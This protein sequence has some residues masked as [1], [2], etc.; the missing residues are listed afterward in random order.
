MAE[1]DQSEKPLFD[2]P[3]LLKNYY[4]F[5]L[6]RQLGL[7]AHSLFLALLH[8][9]NS[10]HFRRFFQISSK[11]LADLAVLT[12]RGARVARDKLLQLRIHGIPLVL[13]LEGNRGRSPIYAIIYEL[14]DGGDKDFQKIS[15]RVDEFIHILPT[16]GELRSSIPHLGE[17][18][19]PKLENV[20]NSG[21]K[22]S[23]SAPQVELEDLSDCSEFSTAEKF[24]GTRFPYRAELSTFKKDRGTTCRDHNNKISINT[25]PINSIYT[26][27]NNV[28]KE[29]EE[30]EKI[31]SNREKTEEEI[32]DI[33]ANLAKHSVKNKKISRELAKKYTTSFIYRHI[34]QI[35]RDHRAGQKWKDPGAILVTRIRKE[36]ETPDF[37]EQDYP[38]SLYAQKF[39]GNGNVNKT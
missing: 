16:L 27:A 23:N 6:P 11:E 15:E 32:Q 3:T 20:D 2:Y 1:Q 34:M 33:I 13:Y 8:K 21:K 26:G 39:A 37:P 38:E 5:G 17:L 30:G 31:F 4:Q 14:L 35:N 28:P 36:Q 10:L 24:R 25:P 12:V 9:A 7:G 29:G 19:S 18:R 22:G